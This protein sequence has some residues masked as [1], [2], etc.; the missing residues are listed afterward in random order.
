MQDDVCNPI[1]VDAEM[2]QEE[3]CSQASDTTIRCPYEDGSALSVGSPAELGASEFVAP[4]KNVKNELGSPAELSAAS[5][6]PTP[7]KQ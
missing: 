1:D 5:E 7:L 3:A 4:V 2:S 6:W